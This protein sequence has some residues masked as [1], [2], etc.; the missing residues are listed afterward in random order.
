MAAVTEIRFGRRPKFHDWTLTFVLDNGHTEESRPG[1]SSR[2][3]IAARAAAIAYEQ[4]VDLVEIDGRGR[5]ISRTPP[6][7][8]RYVVVQRQMVRYD[9][10]HQEKDYPDD[11]R[12]KRGIYHPDDS[13]GWVWYETAWE[14]GAVVVGIYKT[15]EAAMAAAR[16]KTVNADISV[17]ETRH[18]PS[19]G[20]NVLSAIASVV[21]FAKPAY[22]LLWYSQADSEK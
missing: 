13:W 6:G 22:T 4:G 9:K 18:N 16:K 8:P 7:P 14:P 21:S 11:T 17:F 19:R 2:A 20:D 15:R 12:G 1:S 10:R 5:E 3:L